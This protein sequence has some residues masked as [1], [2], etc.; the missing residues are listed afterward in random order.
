[1]N[2]WVDPKMPMPLKPCWR[3]GATTFKLK[4]KLNDTTGLWVSWLECSKECRAGSPGFLGETKE[5]ARFL[6]VC[7]WNRRAK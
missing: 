7:W 4:V 6:C 3:C 1:M 2:A 5:E